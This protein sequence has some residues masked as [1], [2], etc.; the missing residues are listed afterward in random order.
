MTSARRRRRRACSRGSPRARQRPDPLAAPQRLADAARL[1]PRPPRQRR[2][3][4][5][6]R[7][8]LRRV[9]L[10]AGLRAPAV[11]A[12][13]A[14]R[15]REGPGPA[16]IELARRLRERGLAARRRRG[17]DGASA[18]AAPARGRCARQPGVVGATPRARQDARQLGAQRRRVLRRGRRRR[19]AGAARAR[20]LELDDHPH[21]GGARGSPRRLLERLDHA[22]AERSLRADARQVQRL[23]VRLALARV[24]LG[25]GARPLD[26]LGAR[27]RR[28]ATSA[29]SG[30]CCRLPCGPRGPSRARSRRRP[31]T[32]SYSPSALPKTSI[33]T[34][35]ARSSSVANI[36]WS[37]LRVR[38]RLV[39]VMIP[40]TVTGPCRGARRAR[41]AGSRCAA[42]SAS[43]SG[44]SG[45]SEM[46]RPIA[47]F[48]A[49]SSSA[50]SNSSPGSAGAP[51]ANAPPGALAGAAV[52][53]FEVEDRALP[54]HARPAGP[55][56]PRPAPARAPSSMPAAGRAGRAERA[57]LDQRLD[58]LLVD[59]AV[60]DALAEVPQRGER[61]R[62]RARA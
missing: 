47:S 22:S 28:A 43:C 32:A 15:E 2:R 19:G 16:E 24:G 6:G 35:P 9:P 5:A 25:L 38:I 61:R 58:R 40:P 12:R 45:C 11:R 30:T 59:R 41:R 62:P 42:R 56:G 33:S 49:A 53:V 50:C 13:D 8:G 52:A 44:F 60:V 17:S 51:C 29:R 23:R 27:A 46:N 26:L 37:P 36:M 18:G 7:E 34:A 3:G 10:G 14:G 57:A 4:R 54:D 55:S 39:S 31:S 1:Q 20:V 21:L 48:S